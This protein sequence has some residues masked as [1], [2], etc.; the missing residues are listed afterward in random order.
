MLACHIIAG[1]VIA[2]KINSVPVALTIAFFSHYLLDMVPHWEYSLQDLKEK[3]RG[4]FFPKISKL[5]TD[6]II[7][8]SLVFF[9]FPHQPIIF[10]GSLFGILPDIL[11]FVYWLFPS[12]IMTIYHNLHSKTHFWKT[13]KIPVILGISTQVALILVS[14]IF[15]G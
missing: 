6:I 8:F 10:I 12:K 14:I 15:L 5:I 1:A 11:T 4:K 13:K 9:F 2:S 7:G 3:N